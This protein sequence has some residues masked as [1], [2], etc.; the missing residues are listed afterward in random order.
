MYVFLCTYL[1]VS[2]RVHYTVLTLPP[3]I[4]LLSMIQCEL[5]LF[6]PQV[7]TYRNTITLM[8]ESHRAAEGSMAYVSDKGDL[9]VRARDGWRKVQVLY[10]VTV[11]QSHSYVFSYLKAFGIENEMLPVLIQ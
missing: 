5:P 11:P 3:W 1:C 4:Y 6:S 9:Y 8:R 7:T 10:A 2:L